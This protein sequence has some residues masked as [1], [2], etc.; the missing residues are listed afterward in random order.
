MGSD[1]VAQ[2]FA[3]LRLENL[4]GWRSYHLS[5]PLF[6]HVTVPMGII[7]PCYKVDH[8]L[9]CPRYAPP[10]KAWLHLLNNLPTDVGRLLLGLPKA[11]PS[12][13]W[14]SP[15][16]PASPCRAGAPAPAILAAPTEL[17]PVYQCLSYIGQGETWMQ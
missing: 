9:S 10:L 5:R 6:K 3:C 17:T 12:Q 14:T 7:S 8:S 16:P 4:Q 11:I 13:G 2:D 1:Q 15:A